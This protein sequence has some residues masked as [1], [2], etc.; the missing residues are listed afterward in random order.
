MTEDS[1]NFKRL[2]FEAVDEGLLVL[3][4]SGRDAVYF[5][6]E[7]LYSLRKEDVLEKPDVFVESLRKIFGM[8]AGVIEKAILKSL[9]EKLG[10]DY[11]EDKNWDFAAYLNEAKNA[12]RRNPTEIVEVSGT[13]GILS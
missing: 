7:S 1:T 9:Y 11:K 4:K 6:L 2:L 10:L 13:S 5:H 12:V 8:G 3:G